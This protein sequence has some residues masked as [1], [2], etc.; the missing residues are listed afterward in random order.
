MC[1]QQPED[2][3]RRPRQFRSHGPTTHVTQCSLTLDGSDED[4]TAEEDSDCD[5]EDAGWKDAPS[6]DDAEGAA[7]CNVVAI[8]DPD[9]FPAR[10][11][12]VEAFDAQPEEDEYFYDAPSWPLTA[13]A[14]GESTDNVASATSSLSLP[15]QNP[16]VTQSSIQTSAILMLAPVLVTDP[17]VPEST[18]RVTVFLD[19]GSTKT[20]VSAKFARSMKLRP[21][22]REL[23]PVK[24]FGSNTRVNIWS[25]RF[26]I[27]VSSTVPGKPAV[28]FTVNSA[29][30]LLGRLAPPD[31]SNEDKE[32]VRKAGCG[33]LLPLQ[34]VEPDILIGLDYLWQLLRIHDQIITPGGYALLYTSLGPIL[35]GSCAARSHEI[36]FSALT[37]PEADLQ[38]M[39]EQFWVLEALGI[40]DSPHANEDDEAIEFLKNTI[41]F[42]EGRYHVKWPMKS[43]GSDLGDHLQFAV[44]FLR[45]LFRRFY[46]RP[47]ILE[48]MDASFRR[49]EEAGVTE[50]VDFSKPPEGPVVHYLAHFPVESEK[51][52]RVVCNGKGK[53]RASGKSVNDVLVRG[54]VIL[55]ALLGILLRIRLFAILLIADVKKA[56]HQIGLQLPDRD[57]VRFLWV[58]DVQ[59]PPTW[60]NIYVGRFRRV[61]FGLKPSP[62][63]LAGTIDYHL[64]QYDKN[65]ANELRR[66]LYVDNIFLG[67]L[68]ATEAVAKLQE[69]KAIFAD[70]G[71]ELHEFASTDDAVNQLLSTLGAKPSPENIKLLGVRCGFISG[72]L[73]ES[74]DVHTD[75]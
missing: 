3:S 59:K 34:T 19:C 54:P 64:E 9:V 14:A 31:L 23:I 27:D 11:Q 41:V 65:L 21:G 12:D 16:V 52:L 20:Y 13:A 5:V 71:M 44:G 68:T 58:R 55:Q 1:A 36:A 6:L 42:E 70:A 63:L 30:Y 66:N 75:R 33:E 72:D 45:A 40:R 56:F 24:T 10:S 67:A 49:D 32:F 18:R 37:D 26:T 38:N 17:S 8:P 25:E 60:D 61:P 62:F 46:D 74:D 28:T 57:L 47:D 22:V 15:P 43:D 51:K 39:L 48:Q 7:F 29:P 69:A 73:N 4:W 53:D 35:T 2:A 50:R